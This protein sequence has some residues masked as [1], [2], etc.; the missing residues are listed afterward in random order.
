MITLEEKVKLAKEIGMEQWAFINEANLQLNDLTRLKFKPITLDAIREMICPEA[1][2]NLYNPDRYQIEKPTWWKYYC[3]FGPE[4]IKHR[5]PLESMKL[6][7]WKENIPYGALLAVK[8][9][10]AA[11]FTNFQI[12]FPVTPERQRLKLDPVITGIFGKKEKRV[13]YAN[14]TDCPILH[15]E[16]VLRH[17]HL[18][19]VIPGQLMEVFA[20]DD[21]KIYD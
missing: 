3:V 18:I 20:W 12:H 15:R 21:R 9:A 17:S 19:T 4:W 10:K 1:Y 11:G 16:S 7:E 13:Q 2:F 14:S 6:E 8:E 5:M